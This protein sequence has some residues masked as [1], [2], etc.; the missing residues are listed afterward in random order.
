MLGEVLSLGVRVVG[1]AL[2]LAGLWVS[3]EVVQEVGALPRPCTH[4]DARHRD[5]TRHG[6]RRI[7]RWCRCGADGATDSLNAP[8]LSFLLAWFI[9]P[10][11]LFTAGY[12]AMLA[13][14]TGGAL[15]LGQPSGA[16][17]FSAVRA[18]L[19]Q[20][21]VAWNKLGLALARTAG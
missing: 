20:M 3:L 17:L 21:H 6:H 8:K 9:A 1:V 15:A 5:G 16:D 4:C 2:L 7:A 11:L 19:H 12:L 14:R 18:Q 10:V 13:V